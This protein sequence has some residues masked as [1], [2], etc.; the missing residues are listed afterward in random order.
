L[1]KYNKNNDSAFHLFLIS[2]NNNAK[3]TKDK[4]LNFLKNNK[5]L[6]QYHYVPIY[7]FKLFNQKINLNFYKGAEFYYKNT[8][9]LPIFYNLSLNHQ[10][11]IINK[12]ITFLKR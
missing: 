9:S 6:C 8:I 5:I 3:Y 4:L 2:L 11:K 7:K 12:I 10:K 1:P